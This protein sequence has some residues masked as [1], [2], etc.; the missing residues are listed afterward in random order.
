MKALTH[1]LLGFIF[2]AL[3]ACFVFIVPHNFV[4]LF[5]FYIECLLIGICIAKFLDWNFEITNK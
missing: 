3:N 4:A 1:F 2:S 5:L